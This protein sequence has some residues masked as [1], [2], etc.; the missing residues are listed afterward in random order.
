MKILLKRLKYAFEEDPRFQITFN[1]FFTY[2]WIVN[3]FLV[4]LLVVFFNSFWQRFA[5][6]YL[7]EASLYAN[8]AT[9]YSGLSSAEASEAAHHSVSVVSSLPQ[10]EETGGE[11]NAPNIA[12]PAVTESVD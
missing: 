5:I 4:P 11:K 3:F 12:T 2:F 1:K 10:V 8:I 7:T 6:P 9:N